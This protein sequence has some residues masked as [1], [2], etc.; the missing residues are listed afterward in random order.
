MINFF[1]T[2]TMIWL[3]CKDRLVSGR[4]QEICYRG[5]GAMNS[6]T[7]FE[8]SPHISTRS[9]TRRWM[10]PNVW[11]WKWS[12][13]RHPQ[14]YGTI[15]IY[16]IIMCCFC[17]FWNGKVGYT[18]K[19]KVGYTAKP[20]FRTRAYIRKIGT[21]T[22]MQHLRMHLLLFWD[23]HVA[24]CKNDMIEARQSWTTNSS[25]HILYLDPEHTR[26]RRKHVPHFG[27]T[28]RLIQVI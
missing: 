2:A 5:C 20:Y 11:I 7:S 28:C 25:F 8:D 23:P 24:T 26:S 12:N 14:F 27:A 22:I 13:T 3:N 15:Y 16:T 21:I 10:N 18:A 17:F 19:R 1:I 6:S 4:T 9:S